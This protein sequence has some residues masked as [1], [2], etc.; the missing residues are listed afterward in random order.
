MDFKQ[1]LDVALSMTNIHH[2]NNNTKKVLFIVM[3]LKEGIN[4]TVTNL[5]TE[6]I[7]S[8]GDEKEVIFLIQLKI[9]KE[10]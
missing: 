1:D 7:N 8:F 10:L 9:I 4:S 3:P 5:D 6:K 2:S